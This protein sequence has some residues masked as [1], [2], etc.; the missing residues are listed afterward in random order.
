MPPQ[1]REREP[2]ALKAVRVLVLPEEPGKSIQSLVVLLG[3]VKTPRLAPQRLALVLIGELLPRENLVERG[4]RLGVLP[5]AVERPGRVQIRDSE[6]PQL[7]DSTQRR[8]VAGYG[9]QRVF[10]ELIRVGELS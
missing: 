9:G 2:P 3:E 8:L 10:Q 5:L 7:R 1:P 4:D 6:L